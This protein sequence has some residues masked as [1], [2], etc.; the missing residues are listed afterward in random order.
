MVLEAG[1]GHDFL[2]SGNLG[3]CP[4]EFSPSQQ[5]QLDAARS[6]ASDLGRTLDLNA[7][8]RLW[9]GSFVPLGSAAD[10]PLVIA[11]AGPGVLGAL[12]RRLVHAQHLELIDRAPNDESSAEDLVRKWMVARAYPM[13]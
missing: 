3:P 4:S 5:R 2:R 7:R 9:D 13:P 10:G 12:I 11:I 1:H 6:L 8:V